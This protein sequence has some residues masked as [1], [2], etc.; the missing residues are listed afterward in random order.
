MSREQAFAIL[1]AAAPPPTSADV[2]AWGRAKSARAFP[3][4]SIRQA[5]GLVAACAAARLACGAPTQANLAELEAREFLI[6]FESFWRRGGTHA[7]RAPQA[8]MRF[9]NEEWPAIWA[10]RMLEKI[11]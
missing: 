3:P 11:K 4:D 10:N 2:E 8:Y 5:R 7:E 9:V 1:V 6:R